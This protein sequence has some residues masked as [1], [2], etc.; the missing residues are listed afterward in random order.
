MLLTYFVALIIK[1]NKYT[2]KDTVSYEDQLISIF[3]GFTLIQQMYV[4]KN[5]KIQ[6]IQ[7]V[8]LESGKED[9]M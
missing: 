2:V 5:P 8:S 3:A 9:K 7:S 1:H 4:I 6:I